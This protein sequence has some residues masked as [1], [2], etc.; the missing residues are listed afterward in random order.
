MDAHICI[1]WLL[2]GC[3]FWR[4]LGSKSSHTA[5]QLSH[6]RSESILPAAPCASFALLLLLFLSFA[7]RRCESILWHPAHLLLPYSFSPRLTWIQTQRKSY[8][9]CQVPLPC[10]KFKMSSQLSEL[11][12]QNNHPTYL[13]STGLHG[14]AEKMESTTWVEKHHGAK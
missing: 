4:G 9:H 12:L 5:A 13:A 10:P 3:L 6:R 8:G 1:S 7:H 11:A 2:D 14:L